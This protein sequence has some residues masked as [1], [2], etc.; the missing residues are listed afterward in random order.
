[1][2]HELM[3]IYFFFHKELTRSIRFTLQ[4]MKINIIVSLSLYIAHMQVIFLYL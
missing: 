3:S 1:M 2:I 4:Y